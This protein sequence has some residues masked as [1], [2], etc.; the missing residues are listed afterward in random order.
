MKWKKLVQHLE[1]NGRR[2]PATVAEV[3][4]SATSGKSGSFSPLDL[5]GL[6][7]GNEEEWT[8]R[9]TRLRIRPEGEPEFEVETKVRYARH[10][11][12]DEGDEI[13]VLYDPADHELVMV[14]PPETAEY[15]PSKGLGETKVGFTLDLSRWRKK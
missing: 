11:D 15:D 4:G 7:G 1:A 8:S 10:N 5:V 2:A 6:G 12:P 9:K 13:E 14:A 3:S